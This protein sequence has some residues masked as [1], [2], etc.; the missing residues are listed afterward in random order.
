MERQQ[1]TLDE[2]DEKLLQAG[3]AAQSDHNYQ[4]GGGAHSHPHS[5]R[6]ANPS[7][8]PPIAPTTPLASRAHN[9]TT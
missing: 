8:Q 1:A 2:D 5:P 9:Q 4:E 6:L 3:K 7:R